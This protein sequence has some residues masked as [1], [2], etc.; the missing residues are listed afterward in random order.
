MQFWAIILQCYNS[1]N[2]HFGNVLR[3]AIFGFELNDDDV[4]RALIILV[5]ELRR[6]TSFEF[7]RANIFK[8]FD[9]CRETV[10]RDGRD[11]A[12]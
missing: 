10:E 5:I 11:E 12:S 3:F 6:V 8:L 7:C 4:V 1:E 2:L 9:L